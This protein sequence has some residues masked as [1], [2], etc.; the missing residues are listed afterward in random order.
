MPCSDDAGL[1]YEIRPAK[2]SGF[3]KGDPFSQTRWQFRSPW[4]GLGQTRT[5]PKRKGAL[6]AV[7]HASG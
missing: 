2:A 1:A 6:A 5:P 3:G 4:R 7:D